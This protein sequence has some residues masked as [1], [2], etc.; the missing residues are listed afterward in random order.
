MD[1]YL[2]SYPADPPR[3]RPALK[4]PFRFAIL[5]E[6][7]YIKNAMSVGA[8]A[9]KQLKAQTR[10]ALTGADGEPSGRAV[11]DLRFRA[12]GLPQFVRAVH[13]SLWHGRGGRRAAQP[14]PAVP[15]AP[16]EGRRCCAICLKVEITLTADMTEERRRV[17]Q[18]SLL[19]LRP[20]VEGMFSG[21]NR[22]E[23]LAAITE[24]R[25]ICGHPSLVLP[26]YA[27][28]SGKL[29]LLLVSGSLEAG[30]PRSS[31][32]CSPA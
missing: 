15:A 30:T 26:S 20:Q 10:L 18:A 22:I 28:S 29:D 24:L 6:A 23:M 1:V 17:Y 16:P 13:A 7:Q 2:T 12:A 32:P 14:H 25:Q 11:V 27:A 4:V 31:S 5:D 3:H 21:N 8:G 19:R 9:V